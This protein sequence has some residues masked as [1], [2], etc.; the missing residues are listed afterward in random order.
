MQSQKR[1][2][3][4]PDWR[5]SLEQVEILQGL[6]RQKPARKTYKSTANTKTILHLEASSKPHQLG[7]DEDLLILI[8]RNLTYPSID[9]KLD[10]MLIPTQ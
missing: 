5:G 3:G 7:D 1:K 10:C 6:P 8:P 4:M 2:G 9:R